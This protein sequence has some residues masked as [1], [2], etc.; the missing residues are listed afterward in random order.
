MGDDPVPCAR[1]QIPKPR[2]IMTKKVSVCRPRKSMGRWGV[3]SATTVS[4]DA[5]ACT[6]RSCQLMMLPA[7]TWPLAAR[8]AKH[9][10]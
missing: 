6:R 9:N 8:A 5:A 1:P 10:T 2:Q 3:Y 7:R 4:A